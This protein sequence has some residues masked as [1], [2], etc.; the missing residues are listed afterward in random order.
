VQAYLSS[1]QV[2]P[3]QGNAHFQ[4]VPYQAFET[5]DGWLVLAVG[6]D[7]Q[8][9]RFC[10]AAG[11]DDLADDPRF[12]RNAGRV[13]QRDT[14]VPLIEAVMRQRTTRE[15]QDLLVKVDV[16]CAPVLDYAQILAEPQAA[17]RGLK[18]TVTDP[19]GRPIDLVGTPFHIDGTTLPAPQAPHATLR[20]VLKLDEKQI[21]ELRQQGVIA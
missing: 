20:D 15:W 5:A 2:P 8:Y 19:D 1:G 9:R 10:H 12:V 18:V 13:E 4:I 7:A 3:R 6:N 11:R 17:A 14:L 16:P 21:A